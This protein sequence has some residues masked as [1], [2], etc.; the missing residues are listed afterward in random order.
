M[1]H[2]IF[3][4]KKYEYVRGLH[5]DVDCLLCSI[6]RRDPAVHNLEVYRT[7]LSSISINL[8]PYN[9]GHL[10]IFP[11]SHLENL[12]ELSWE[13]VLDIERCTRLSMDILD[14]LYQP[15][16]YNIGYNLGD[17]SGASIRHLHRHLIPRY[18]NELGFVD[19]IAGSKIIVE[20]P[21][22]TQERLLKAFGD[23]KK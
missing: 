7:E 3:S 15:H 19:I 16:G 4:P 11:L 9:S 13:E 14:H 17:W 21:K 5:P 8:Y 2:Y 6:T 20:D 1:M 10:L 12:R 18:R 23:M 22:V